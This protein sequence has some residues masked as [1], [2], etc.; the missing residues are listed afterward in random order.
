MSCIVLGITCY[1][2]RRPPLP[3]FPAAFPEVQAGA[4]DE[5]GGFTSFTS[6]DGIVYILTFASQ[7]P[8][9]RNIMCTDRTGR[10]GRLGRNGAV[11]GRGE[12]IGTCWLTLIRVP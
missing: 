10:S 12:G 6:L 9:G 5:D 11:M 7:V 4:Q 8:N 3:P 2:L 1:P